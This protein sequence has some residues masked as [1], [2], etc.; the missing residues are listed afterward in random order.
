MTE[1]LKLGKVEVSIQWA[2]TKLE[3]GELLCFPF[4]LA[5]FAPITNIFF[6]LQEV[7]WKKVWNLYPKL[8]SSKCLEITLSLVTCSSVKEKRTIPFFF[9]LT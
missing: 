7:E 9:F 3:M 4:L 8:A 2:Q 5:P 1:I 6:I